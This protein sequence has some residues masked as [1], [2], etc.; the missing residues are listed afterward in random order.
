VTPE[1]RQ[2]YSEPHRRYHT[3]AHIEDCLAKLAHIDG[4]SD[5]DRRLLEW[6]I[7]W[8][9]AVYDPTRSDNEAVSAEMARRD[10]EGFG[11]S[12]EDRDEVERLILLTRGHTVEPRDRLGA[13]LV[14]IDLSILGAE[15]EVYDRYAAQIREEYAFVPEDAWR[16]GRGAVLQ[17]FLEAET[18]YPDPEQRALYE[19]PARENLA[20]ELASLQG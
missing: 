18:L 16:A 13:V 5:Q 3:L 12:A 8:H 15:P 2:A 9:D 11:A 20:R 17:R 4:L 10:L 14:S 19:T 7:W 6:A 1:L